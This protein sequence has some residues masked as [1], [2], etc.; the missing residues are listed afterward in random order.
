MKAFQPLLVLDAN[1][2]VRAVLGNRVRDLLLM[3]SEAV[4]FLTPDVC[5]RDAEKYLPSLFKKRNLPSESALLVLSKLKSIVQLVEEDV[6]S[7]HVEEAM[8][9]IKSRDLHDWP[10][11]ATAL[12]F[13]CPVWTED[14]DF[15]GSG[16]SVWTS[17]RIHIFFG[18]HDTA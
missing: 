12:A 5:F 15:F 16:L 18:L 4:S 9:R 6:Y 7:A 11:V 2:L 13:N 10:I 3:H 1:I 14:Q 17:D 8:E